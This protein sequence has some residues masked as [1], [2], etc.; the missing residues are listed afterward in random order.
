M[1]S[2]HNA[3]Q[4]RDDSGELLDSVERFLDEDLNNAQ[5]FIIEHPNYPL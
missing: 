1:M 3:G 2:W 5:A 4:N